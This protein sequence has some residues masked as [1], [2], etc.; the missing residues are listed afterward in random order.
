MSFFQSPRML[1][2]VSIIYMLLRY[3]RAFFLIDVF[4]LGVLPLHK[5]SLAKKKKITANVK[6]AKEV[7]PRGGKERVKMEE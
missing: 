6:E 2:H 7:K 4:L 5:Y 3:R 1:P